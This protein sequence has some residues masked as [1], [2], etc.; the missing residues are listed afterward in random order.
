MNPEQTE[1]IS[2]SRVQKFLQMCQ[3]I[4]VDIPFEMVND[5]NTAQ[6][7]PIMKKYLTVVRSMKEEAIKETMDKLN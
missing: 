7:N 6:G 1:R 5:E 4:A 2:G 3:K